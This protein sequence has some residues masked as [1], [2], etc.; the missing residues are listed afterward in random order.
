MK[1]IRI[2]GSISS[3]GFLQGHRF[4]IGHWEH[5]PIGSFG[6]VM[7]GT[8]DGRRVLLAGSQ[9]AADF[10]TSIYNFDEVRIGDLQIKSD[11][12]E[13]SAEGLGVKLY[14]SG[15]W[16]RHIPFPRP[17]AF[18]KFIERPIAKRLMGVETFG[19]SSRGISEWY[20]AEQWRWVESGNAELEG[21]DLGLP[22]PFSQPINVGFS[23]PPTKPAIVSLRV[24]IKFP[25]DEGMV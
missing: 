3:A 6:D 22:S 11:G 7:W 13:T 9:V 24:A 21:T 10:V 17:L 8:P 4:V 20:Q 1:I 19:T 16:A 18:T 2:K 15:G 25:S 5:S 12:R 23:E 14:F